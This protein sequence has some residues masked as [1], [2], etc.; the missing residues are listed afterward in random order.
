MFCGGAGGSHAQETVST[1]Y[2][3]PSEVPRSGQV[4]IY[5]TMKV[6]VDSRKKAGVSIRRRRQPRASSAMHFGGGPSL[7][8]WPHRCRTDQPGRFFVPPFLKHRCR[9]PWI[10]IR[11]ALYDDFGKFF[12]L[13]SRRVAGAG[14]A[15]AAFLLRLAVRPYLP[16]DK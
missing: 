12:L 6:G 15:A 1:A 16:R 13:L 8:S 10:S 2:D 5:N 7:V 9:R 11:K 3:N 4:S 14:T